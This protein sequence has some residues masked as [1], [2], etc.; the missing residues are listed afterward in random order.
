MA[1]VPGPSTRKTFAI[2][3]IAIA[4]IFIINAVLA[5]L[6]ADWF[7]SVAFIALGFGSVIQGVKMLNHKH[8][9]NGGKN[10]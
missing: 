9:G 3:F 5:I 7:F 2:L 6:R 1:V 4:V 8:V 10:M